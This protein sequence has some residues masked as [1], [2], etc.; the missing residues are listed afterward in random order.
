MVS[1]EG[2]GEWVRRKTHTIA[3]VPAGFS[4]LDRVD[5]LTVAVFQVRAHVKQR[6]RDV[7]VAALLPHDVRRGS[8]VEVQAAEGVSTMSVMKTGT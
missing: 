1:E 6:H 7:T 3:R 4:E 5:A 8:E 2:D